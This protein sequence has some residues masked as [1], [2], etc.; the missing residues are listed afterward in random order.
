MEL[1]AD[2]WPFHILSEIGENVSDSSSASGSLVWVRIYEWTSGP[3][4]G[5]F[6][7]FWYVRVKGTSCPKATFPIHSLLVIL[8]NTFCL[9]ELWI[10]NPFIHQNLFSITHVYF[11][12][13]NCKVSFVLFGN[14]KMSGGA[15]RRW[16]FKSCL[17]PNI[18]MCGCHHFAWPF[19]EFTEGLQERDKR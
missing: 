9:W 17:W 19:Q 14:R 15:R 16:R 8:K 5:R 7:S 3:S 1:S 18:L 4:S 13:T 2:L 6:L 11:S 12:E 10:N